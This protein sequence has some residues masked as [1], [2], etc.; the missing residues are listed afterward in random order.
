MIPPL[1]LAISLCLAPSVPSSSMCSCVIGRTTDSARAVAELGTDDVIFI[2]RVTSVVDTATEPGGVVHFRRATFTVHQAWKGPLA[3]SITIFTPASGGGCGFQFAV[4]TQY[5]VFAMAEPNGVVHTRGCSP[6]QPLATARKYL[7]GLGEPRI[8]Y[9]P[10]D[11][12]SQS[13]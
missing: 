4:G 2:G 9:A 12:G 13:R 11:S 8:R 6:T 10:A 1:L 5:L 7:V 3:R